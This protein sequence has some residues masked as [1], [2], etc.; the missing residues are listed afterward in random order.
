MEYLMTW[1]NAYVQFKAN[2]QNKNYKQ[3]YLKPVKLPQG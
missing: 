2:H 3:C 1:K